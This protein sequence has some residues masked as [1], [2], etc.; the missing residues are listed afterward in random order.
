MKYTMLHELEQNL[1]FSS[2]FAFN[3]NAMPGGKAPVSNERQ[4]SNSHRQDNKTLLQKFEEFNQPINLLYNNLRIT[5]RHY[6]NE[7]Q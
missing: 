2:H 6:C 4:M 1:K 3:C 5:L 7:K